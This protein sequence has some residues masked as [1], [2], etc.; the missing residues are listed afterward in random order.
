MGEF[1]GKVLWGAFLLLFWTSVSGR[2]MP[3]DVAAGVFVISLILIFSSKLIPLYSG[4]NSGPVLRYQ[5][6][7]CLIKYIYFM[8]KDIILANIHVA[9]IV[10]SPCLRIAPALVKHRHG[11]CK[12]ITGFLYANSITLT[13]GTLTVEMDRDWIM[14]HL[15]D[16][17]NVQ[18]LT[19]WK[20]GEI[21]AEMEGGF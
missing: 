7:L 9:R 19:D 6:L 4:G 10:L 11:L 20:V 17:E 18:G 12:R 14:V 3:E 2:V 13:P 21:L 15:L 16:R 5:T 1:K 8:V